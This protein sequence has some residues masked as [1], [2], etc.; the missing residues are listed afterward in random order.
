M[1]SES[2][3]FR[4]WQELMEMGG[5]AKRILK[6]AM[7]QVHDSADTIVAAATAAAPAGDGSGALTTASRAGEGEP[8]S[9]GKGERL[10]G[11]ARDV[12][13]LKQHWTV[14]EMAR[15]KTE[16]VLKLERVRWGAAIKQKTSLLWRRNV[17]TPPSLPSL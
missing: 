4:P 17:L 8:P 2:E 10:D 7:D 1:E 12:V 14:A 16:L 11:E 9:Q 15:D 13:G 5:R 3:F 6:A